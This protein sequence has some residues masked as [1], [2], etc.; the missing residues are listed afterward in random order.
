MITACNDDN[1]NENDNEERRMIE[2][3]I[4]ERGKVKEE[5]EHRKD[6]MNKTHT[7]NYRLLHKRET[8][9]HNEDSDKVMRE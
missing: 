2:M 8:S 3:L 1:D 7:F 4:S 9:N 5:S 6:T